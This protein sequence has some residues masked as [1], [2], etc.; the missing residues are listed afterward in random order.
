MSPLLFNIYMAELEERLEKRGI[1]GVAISNKRIWNLAYADD[2]VLVAKNREAMMDMMLTLKSFLKD[3]RM[4]LNTEKSKILVFN[5]K[6]REKKGR[7]VW[8]KKEI[9]E[10]HTFNT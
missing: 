10:I 1:G 4:E 2:I 8:K 3:R 9:E 6:D 7:W 5:R